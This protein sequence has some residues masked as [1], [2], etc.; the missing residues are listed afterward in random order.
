[1]SL[2]TVPNAKKSLGC[3]SFGLVDWGEL[4]TMVVGRVSVT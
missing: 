3:V 4:S 1:M 2:C